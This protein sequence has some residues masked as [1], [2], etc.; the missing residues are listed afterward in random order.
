MRRDRWTTLHRM[1]S[2]LPRR[3]AFAFYYMLYLYSLHFTS[4]GI[5]RITS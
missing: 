4:L 3:R 1:K 5:A 2:C